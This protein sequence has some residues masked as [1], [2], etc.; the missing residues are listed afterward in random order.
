LYL[1][2]ASLT[3][4]TKVSLTD[5]FSVQVEGESTK[6]QGETENANS[7]TIGRIGNISADPNTGAVAKDNEDRTSGSWN[8]T[9]G[10]AKESIGN[11][12]GSENLRQQG[13]NQNQQ[14]KEQE[15][16]G[17][18]ADLGAG[19]QNR[20]Q[21]ALG[22]VGAAV[23]GDRDQQAKY[24]DMHDEGK[25]RQRGVEAELQKQADAGN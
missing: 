16:K 7:H 13:I 6:L 11:L 25:A 4:A 9:L 5:A 19:I 14:G 1:H 21:G 10:S 12:I 18:L 23:L 3:S 24:Q 15:A 20:A 8:Q 2:F 22:N 17:Q